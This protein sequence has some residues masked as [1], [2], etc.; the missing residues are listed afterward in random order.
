[1]TKERLTGRDWVWPLIFLL[2][3]S[4]GASIAF[5]YHREAFPEAS[6]DLKL[7]KEEITTRSLDF[8]RGRNLSPEGYRRFT[9]FDF[10]DQAKIYLEREMGMEEASRLMSS[11]KIWRWKTRFMKPPS[12]EEI[13]VRL[14]PA[15]EL[16][17]FDH[18]VE[19]KRAGAKL[20]KAEAQ[21]IAEVFLITEKAFDLINYKLVSDELTTWPNRL[22]YNFTWEQNDVKFKEATARV[23]VTVQGD[24]VGGYSEFLKIPDQWT[25]DYE[26]M[27]SRNDLLTFVALAMYVV[28]LSLALLVVTRSTREKQTRWKA[29]IIIGGVVGLLVAV[30]SWNEMPLA[31]QS[32]PTNTP[33]EVWSIVIV[34][35]ALLGGFFTGIYCMLLAASGEPLYRKLAPDRVALNHLF[36][37]SGLRT[38]E[39]FT[40]TLIGYGMAGIVIGYQ[41]IFYMLARRFGAWAPMDINYDNTISTALPWIAPMAV[42]VMAATTEEFGFRLFAIPLMLRWTNSR[43]I[44]LIVPAFLWGFLHSNYPQQPAWIRGVEVGTMG[45]ITGWVFLRFG[46]LAT[47]VWHY[48]VDAI[49]GALFLMRSEILSFRIAGALVGDA[50]LLPLII[51]VVF[52]IES[53][54]FLKDDRLLNGG[55]DAP[56][57]AAPKAEVGVETADFKVPAPPP[58][59]PARAFPFIRPVVMRVLAALGTIALFGSFYLRS[60]GTGS[61]ITIAVTKA[62][63]EEKAVEY[64]KKRGVAADDYRRVTGFEDSI[65]GEGNDYLRERLDAGKVAEIYS[66]QIPSVFWHTRFFKPLQKEEYSVFVRPDGGVAYHSHQLD[67]K[68][69]GAQLEKPEALER[70]EAFLKIKGV[71]LGDFHVVEHKLERRVARDDHTITWES[72]AKLAGEANHRITMGVK[73]DEVTGPHHFVKLPEE[74]KRERERTTVFPF[75]VVFMFVGL[76]LAGVIFA[77]RAVS[78]ITPQWRMHITLGAVGAVLQLARAI[79]GIP[80]WAMGY[81]TAK[82]WSNSVTQDALGAFMAVMGAFIGLASLGIVAEMLFLDRFPGM[83]VWPR[84][85][86]ER[87]RAILEGL[88]AGTMASLV[89]STINGATSFLL[90]KIP[91]VQRGAP[92]GVPGHPIAFVDAMQP[93]LDASIAALWIALLAGACAAALLRTFRHPAVLGLALAAGTALLASAAALNGVHFAKIWIGML[94]SVAAMSALIVILR[95]NLYSYLAGAIL[96]GLLNRAASLWRHPG[97]HSIGVDCVVAT[98]LLTIAAL[99]WTH[100]E[101]QHRTA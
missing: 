8:L 64:L 93:L 20:S 99:W 75:L 34:L 28:M 101:L 58:P 29:A 61:D 6:I 86:S 10:D 13:T 40:S 95:F 79:N 82:A 11:L 44:A 54:G 51:S 96:G 83:S 92:V 43:W 50:V 21:R 5:K 26:R 67:E 36:T 17:G 57:P 84:A 73:G 18:K 87:A 42:G 27:R 16:V 53:R 7:T 69:P 19:E 68:V 63:A 88:I 91:S 35:L 39:F 81:D 14:T 30:Q 85:G 77:A 22:D 15:G 74:W 65:G 66:Q 55:E 24:Q 38:K 2:L 4:V 48:T 72:N 56:R 90:D 52:Y 31:F 1:M 9:V 94:V 98:A 25:R 100:R 49:L 80:G 23:R 3:G 46:I 78:R 33:Y 71:H 37:F 59:A 47:L 45:V 41:V 89:L 70:A 97:L 62:Q 60:R 76:G 12:T 32:L